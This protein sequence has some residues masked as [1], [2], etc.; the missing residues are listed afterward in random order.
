MLTLLSLNIMHGILY[1]PSRGNDLLLQ[2]Y[3]TW[4]VTVYA[5]STTMCAC[6]VYTSTTTFQPL[7]VCLS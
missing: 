1:W 6:A 2:A 3:Y 4:I 5:Q 7:V